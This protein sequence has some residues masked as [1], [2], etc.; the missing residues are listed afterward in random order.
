MCR[1][2]GAC[3]CHGGGAG[4]GGFLV[5]LAAGIVRWLLRATWQALELLVV[6]L[7]AGLVWATPRAWRLSVRI[8]RAGWR[9]WQTRG[10]ATVAA[11]Q[12]APLA[13][14]AVRAVTWTE[15]RLKQEANR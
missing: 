9:R 8:T 2:M 7:V 1:C 10:A 14:E 3:T 11:D 6:A 12:P 13:I 15:L 4:V 5:E